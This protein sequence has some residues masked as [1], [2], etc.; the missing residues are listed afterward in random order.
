VPSPAASPASADAELTDRRADPAAGQDRYRAAISAAVVR[1]WQEI[2]H[3]AVTRELRVGPAVDA[4]RQWRTVLPE[5]TLTDLLVRALALAMLERE[6]RTDLAVGLAVATDRGV[7]IPVLRNVLG[8]G[9]VEL[10]D[11]RRAAVSRA[12]EGRLHP[13]D[14]MV[15]ITTL[16]NLGA[17]GV[18]QFTGV[19]PHGQ[20]SMLTVGRAADRPVVHDGALAVACT[21][22]ATLNVDHRS[23]DGLHA[24]QALD[25]LARLL[26]APEPLLTPSAPGA[27]AAAK[28]SA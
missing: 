2:P 1:S 28:E 7:A 26:A 14:G 25:R 13:D 20:S 6:R 21:M 24:G 16:S 8:L 12:R 17:V 23:W 19:I 15:P 5:I 4:V 27:P 18:D 11:A 3:F 9:M 10:V 22:Q